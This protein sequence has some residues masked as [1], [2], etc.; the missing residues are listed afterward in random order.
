[1]PADK[2]YLTTKEVAQTLHVNE[3]AIYA[4]ISEKGL[5]ATKVTGKWLFPR[6]LVEEWLEVSVINQ[7]LAGASVPGMTD[8]GRLLIGGSD[9]VLFQRLLGIYQKRYP[10]SPV[11][12]SN[13]GSMGGLKALRRRQCHIAVCHLLQDDNEEYNFRFAEREMDRLPVFVN[14]SK[15][16]QGILVAKGNPKGIASVKD[17][18]RPGIRI[19]NRSLNTGTR[20]LL[21]YEISRCDIRADEIDGYRTEV[22]RHLDAG[23]AVLSGSADAAPAIRPVATMLGL[24]FLPLRWERFDLLIVR[25]SFFNPII[26]RF[27]NLL[28]DPNF[29]QSATE[30]VGYDLSVSGKMV[31]PDNAQI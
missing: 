18:A 21:D 20:L 15:R 26:Q 17:L 4:L 13:L 12:F 30:F 31:Y 16:Q 1:M 29:K 8:D 27:I 10:D 25:E 9:D 23:L 3:K 7:P 6:H 22:A 2:T 14:F 24:D 5:P 11:F 19:V 28:H